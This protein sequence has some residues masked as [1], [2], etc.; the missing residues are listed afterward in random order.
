MYIENNLPVMDPGCPPLLFKCPLRVPFHINVRQSLYWDHV[1][2]AEFPSYADARTFSVEMWHQ[3]LAV[4]VVT[5]PF[6]FHGRQ[7]Q[8]SPSAVPPVSVTLRR[9]GA[10]ASPGP[11]RSTRQRDRQEQTPSDMGLSHRNVSSLPIQPEHSVSCM[12]A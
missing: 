2:S 12:A 4:P 6:L 7:A 3:A 8:G 10:N 11:V 9:H 5:L 1:A